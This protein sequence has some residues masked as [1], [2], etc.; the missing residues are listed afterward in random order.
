EEQL[1][2]LLKQLAD[3][4]SDCARQAGELRDSEQRLRQ[5]E[6]Q[7]KALNDPRSASKAQQATIKRE[8]DYRQQL[9]TEESQGQQHEQQ[10]QDLQ[11]QLA[12]YSGLD[13]YIGQQEA[14]REQC[15]AGYNTYLKNQDVAR[16]LPERQHTHQEASANAE[17]SDPDLLAGQQA[18]QGAG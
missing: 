4:I 15:K 18:E 9:Q 17:Q 13:A 1:R 8:P 14:V 3:G 7:I 2:S 12:Q 6:E 10:L 11:Q 16:Q 5:V